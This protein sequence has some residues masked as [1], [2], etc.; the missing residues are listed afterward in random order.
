[1]VS[2]MT[3]ALTIGFVLDDSLDSTDGVQQYVLTLGVWLTEQGHTVHY[4]VGETKRTDVPNIH[5]LSRNVRVKF[6][7]NRLSIPR[8]APKSALRQLFQE[9]DFDVLH[10][11]MPYSPMLAA[12]VI[13]L[14]PAKTA[15]VGT[16]HILPAGGLQASASRLLGVIERKSLRRFSSIVSV[17]EP[18]RQF[19]HGIQ[20]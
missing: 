15:V 4:L 18:A 8:F 13:A 14:A 7:Q 3:K 2:S 12:R 9:V 5:S 10:V 6:N 11:Q 16:F 1:M 17:S 20:G 19:E